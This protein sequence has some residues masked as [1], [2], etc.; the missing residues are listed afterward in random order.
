MIPGIRYHAG[1]IGRTGAPLTTLT[2]HS[3]VHET[4]GQTTSLAVP[5]A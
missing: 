2:Y 5:S 1:L 4:S 3:E